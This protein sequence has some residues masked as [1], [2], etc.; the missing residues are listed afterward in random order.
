MNPTAFAA[1]PFVSRIQRQALVVGVSALALCLFSAY[2]NPAQFFRSYLIA[3]LFYV[4]VALG[5]LALVMLQYLSGGAWGI[6]VRR[7][8]ESATRTLPLLA[9][10]FVP[11]VFGIRY[12]YVWTNTE[13]VLQSERL[14]HQQPYLNASFFIVRAVFYFAVWLTL[15]YLFN[16]W[17]RYQDETGDPL[18]TRKP[19]LL[20]GPGLVLYGLTVTFASI[21]WVM[22]IEPQW[23]STIYGMLFIVGQGL[24]AI[25]F[26]IAVAVL[27]ASRR[28]MSE[29]FT[30]SHF[31]DLG[32]LLLMFIMLWAYLAYS[33]FLL[34]WAGNLPE[35]IPW[36]LHRWKGGWLWV[37]AML[38]LFHF[39]LPFVLLLS[40]QT[41][42]NINRLAALATMVIFMRFV[43]I[44]WLTAPDF[45]QGRFQV[46]WLDIAA[47]IGLG[48]VWLAYFSW[49][50][51]ARPLLPI[52]D[53]FLAIALNTRQIT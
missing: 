8:L 2:F 31:H 13:N 27:L 38:I 53:P 3:Y 1:P 7:L 16:K 24:S 10:L 41:K 5:C 20:S 17:S 28:P 35:E 26:V 9:V 34:I 19:Q 33:Q 6:V 32:K 21:D 23:Y 47:P 25:S 44:F 11:L 51:N 50:L 45:Y 46:H 36:Y 12:L 22:S 48:G 39:A 43:D 49:Q 18:T 15:A 37:G 14:Q 4:G 42:V 52:N 30:A 40:R 29:V